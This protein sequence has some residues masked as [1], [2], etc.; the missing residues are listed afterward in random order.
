MVMPIVCCLGEAAGVAASVASREN[1]AAA[2]ADIA[3]IQRILVE[4]GAVIH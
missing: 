4:N 1:V 2:D 3:T